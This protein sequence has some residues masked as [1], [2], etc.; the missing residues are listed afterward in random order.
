MEID[1][2]LS[3]TDGILLCNHIY[4]CAIEKTLKGVLEQEE[5]FYRA[6]DMIK[7]LENKS[8]IER[9]DKLLY[10]FNIDNIYSEI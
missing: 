10:K 2:E 4:Q 8:D 9:L 3:F 7:K 6:Y 5:I 1:K